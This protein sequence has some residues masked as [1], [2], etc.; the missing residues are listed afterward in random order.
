MS[1]LL[2]STLGIHT[3]AKDPIVAKK[4]EELGTPLMHSYFAQHGYKTMAVGKIF[5]RHVPKDSVDMTGGRREFNHGTGNLKANWPQKGISTDWAMAPESDEVLGDYE[6]ATW[7]VERLQEDHDKPFMLMVGFLRPHVPWYAP[8]K[9]FDLYDKESLALPRYEADDFDDV[10]A[11]SK[12]VNRGRPYPTTD[13]AKNNDQ[14]ADIIH[15]YLASTSFVDHQVGRVLEALENSPYKDNTVIV[16]WSDHGYHLGEKNTFQKHT[17]YERSSSVPLIIAGPKLPSG[18]RTNRVASLLD[19]YPTLV[20]LAGLP[21]NPKN[22]GRSL[23]PLLENPE[24][25]W[26]YVSIIQMNK[27]HFAIQG[28]RF[29]YIRYN[30]GSEELYDHQVDLDEIHNLANNPEYDTVKVRLGKHV[31]EVKKHG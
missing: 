22:E 12:K 2:P 18:Q 9:W 8:K 14:Y 29:R 23:K 1:G 10:P 25:P 27:D 28:E 26:P 20:D 21:A 3:N 7:A 13:W 17:V 15:A 24:T 19:L 31:P 4:A 6:A 11:I 16:L 5:H 30:D